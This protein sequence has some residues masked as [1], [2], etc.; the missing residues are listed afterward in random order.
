MPPDRLDQ[1]GIKGGPNQ[2]AALICQS[3]ER[4]SMAKEIGEIAEVPS[5][6]DILDLAI[7]ACAKIY[8]YQT[9]NAAEHGEARGH[10]PPSHYIAIGAHECLSAIKTIR[11]QVAKGACE[12][13]ALRLG[14][15]C[16]E[17]RDRL[18]PEKCKTCGGQIQHYGGNYAGH[19]I[20]YGYCSTE[21]AAGTPVRA[22]AL[23][24]RS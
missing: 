24:S 1:E 2:K 13:A 17:K 6:I 14:E 18:Q 9:G 7:G 5:L 12:P 22:K 23:A 16:Q 11:Q 19:G 21:C 4:E 10:E 8:G 20:A 15:T 3:R